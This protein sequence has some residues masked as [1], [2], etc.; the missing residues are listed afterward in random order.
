MSERP[1]QRW[2]VTLGDHTVYEGPSQA[3]AE[4]WYCRFQGPG[5]DPVLLRTAWV[6]VK[7]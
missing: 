4:Y 7:P 3:T 2:L 5:N 6:Q 1:P